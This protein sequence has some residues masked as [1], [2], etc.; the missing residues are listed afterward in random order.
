[1]C[2]PLGLCLYS[3]EHKLENS[4][5]QTMYKQLTK[6]GGEMNLVCDQCVV[7]GCYNER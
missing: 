2:F 6:K 3:E 4:V 1:M 7:R 5:S